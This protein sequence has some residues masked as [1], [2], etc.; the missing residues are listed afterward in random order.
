MLEKVR[1]LEKQRN[2]QRDDF[3]KLNDQHLSTIKTLR[4]QAEERGNT[5]SQLRQDIAN[6]NE[7]KRGK[8]EQVKKANQQINA[9]KQ[10]NLEL[11]LENKSFKTDNKVI[12][13]YLEKLV[14]ASN[15]GPKSIEA[16]NIFEEK[17]KRDI[18]Q[19]SLGIHSAKTRDKE[20]D[21]IP[22]D[23]NELSNKLKLDNIT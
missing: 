1:L 11:K 15:G 3:T 21:I 5:I 6:L 19:R 16:T 10:E 20:V 14:S 8:E 23:R 2:E 7:E 17:E 13:N 4:A 18:N 12:V 9:Y 22:S